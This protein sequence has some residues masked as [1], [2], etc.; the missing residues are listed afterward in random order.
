MAKRIPDLTGD[1]M[2]IPED[3]APTYQNSTGQESLDR[4]D[5]G[6]TKLRRKK[7]HKPILTRKNNSNPDDETSQDTQDE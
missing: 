7:R 1:I 6:S 5:Q 4:F 3:T 2:E